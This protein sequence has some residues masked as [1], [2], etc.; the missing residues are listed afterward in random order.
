MATFTAA[1]TE[2]LNLG[3]ASDVNVPLV[4]GTF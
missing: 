3:P 2:A 4:S 1:E